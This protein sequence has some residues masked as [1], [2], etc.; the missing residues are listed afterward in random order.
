ML[1]LAWAGVRFLP[2]A[3]RRGWGGLIAVNV[4]VG[5]WA[6]SARVSAPAGGFLILPGLALACL[7]VQAALWIVA[8]G[9]PPE[10][11]RAGALARSMLR[12]L[13]AWTLKAIFLCV[14]G[15]LALVVL[16]C[17][18]YA[19]ASAGHGFRASEI[20][21]WAPAIDGRGRMVFGAVGIA[22]GLGMLWAA[23]RVSLASAA[24]MASGRVLML[25]TWPATR[26][27]GWSLVL[28]TLLLGAGAAVLVS[29][30]YRLAGPVGDAVA[31]LII[32]GL[33]LPLNVGVTAYIWNRLSPAD[34]VGLA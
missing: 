1:D 32:G 18:A 10:A 24:T 23:A 22:L 26:V 16:L 33:W 17:T 12:L 19:V 15:L 11:W 3:W 6:W 7:A 30:A 25:S 13:G 34:L 31:G 29:A 21:T 9:Q 14:L 8:L 28:I 27:W 2:K 5:L 20:A 4:G